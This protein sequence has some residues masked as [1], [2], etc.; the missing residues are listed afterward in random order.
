[1]RR[2]L[3]TMYVDKPMRGANRMQA[4]AH[5]NRVFRDKPQSMAVAQ[6]F[7]EQ[8][9]AKFREKIALP[10]AMRFRMTPRSDCAMM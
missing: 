7:S 4:I 8:D 2:S 1:M 3:T 10:A 5:V 9:R 6:D